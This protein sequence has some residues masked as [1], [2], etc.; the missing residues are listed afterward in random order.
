MGVQPESKNSIRKIYSSFM[1]IAAELRMQ[2][3]EYLGL[4]WGMVTQ[5]KEGLFKKA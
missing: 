1:I 3:S 5:M 4:Q 2:S